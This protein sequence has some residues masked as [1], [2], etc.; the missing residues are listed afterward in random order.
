M[1]LGALIGGAVS[2]RGGPITGIAIAGIIWFF[3]TVLFEGIRT[4][5]D[6]RNDLLHNAQIIFT[7]LFFAFIVAFTFN[8]DLFHNIFW[9][10]VGMIYAVSLILRKEMN[11]SGASSQLSE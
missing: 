9:M 2:P 3:L 11:Y 8:S 7:S 4:S 6:T 1:L 5:I 10:T